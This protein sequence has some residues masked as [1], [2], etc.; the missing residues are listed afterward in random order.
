MR[1]IS[2]D[3]VQ[4]NR[5]LGYGISLPFNSGGVFTSTFSPREQVRYNLINYILT[6]HGERYMN[7]GYGANL[8][9]YLFEQQSEEND[10]IERVLQ[11]AINSHFSDIITTNVVMNREG[12]GYVIKIKY[13]YRSERE[14]TLEITI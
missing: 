10:G 8:S 2:N 4:F 5:K 6:N 1:F 3:T 9:Y 13:K 14:D 7:V 12:N 11:D